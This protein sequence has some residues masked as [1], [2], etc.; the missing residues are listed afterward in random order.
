MIVISE[1]FALEV[2]L[3]F[4]SFQGLHM[5]ELSLIENIM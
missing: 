1:N 4:K 2:A 5:V 3:N